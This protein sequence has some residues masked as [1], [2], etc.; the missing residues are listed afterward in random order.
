MK[1]SSTYKMDTTDAP[2][3][4]VDGGIAF[5]AVEAHWR[6]GERPTW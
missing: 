1:P 6:Q 3:M 4:L 5:E 2:G